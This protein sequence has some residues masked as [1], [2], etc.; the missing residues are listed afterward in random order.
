M[1]YWVNIWM[2]P[3]AIVLMMGAGRAF[4]LDYWIQPWLQKV[5]GKIWYGKS[6]SIYN[7]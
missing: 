1:F 3:V 7:G 5:L 2:I 4:G 6:K